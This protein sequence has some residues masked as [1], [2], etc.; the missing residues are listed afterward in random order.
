MFF[1]VTVWIGCQCVGLL[2]KYLKP[3]AIDNMEEIKIKPSSDN[4]FINHIICRSAH[5]FMN[6]YPH[7][8]VELEALPTDFA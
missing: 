6:D 1:K 7:L 4:L 3:V 5:S 2:S 8:A